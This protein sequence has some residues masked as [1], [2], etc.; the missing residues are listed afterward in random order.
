MR[1]GL[2]REQMGTVTVIYYCSDNRQLLIALTPA[3][4]DSI[5]RYWPRIAICVYHTRIRRPPP[6]R[7]VPVEYCHNVWYRKNRIVWLSDGGK[8]L[9]IRL[10]VL[11]EFTN[12][13][14]GRTPHDG[15]GRTYA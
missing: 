6:V 13:T 9:K 10:F 5:V 3:V 8:M 1:S 2:C 11:I 14:D 12:V 7:Q 15:I 4:I